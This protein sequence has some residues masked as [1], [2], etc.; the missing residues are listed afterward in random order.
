MKDDKERYLKKIAHILGKQNWLAIGINDAIGIFKSR[1]VDKED[2]SVII[3]TIDGT[4]IVDV[5]H[6]AFREA[7][8]SIYIEEKSDEIIVL[9]SAHITNIVV[10][11]HVKQ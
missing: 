4:Y 5:G 3:S 6:I 7:G 9:N 11:Q 10:K 1:G 8:T 2:L